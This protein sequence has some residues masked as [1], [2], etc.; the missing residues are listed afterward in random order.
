MLYV[1][2]FYINSKGFRIKEC[3]KAQ[4]ANINTNKA[5]TMILIRLDSEQKALSQTKKV[6]TCRINNEIV[7]L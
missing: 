4:Q 6:L 2:C 7:P 1:K 5:K 3:A